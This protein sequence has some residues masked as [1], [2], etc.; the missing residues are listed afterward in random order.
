MM[1]THMLMV[2]F[3]RREDTMEYWLLFGEGM[4]FLYISLAQHGL[5]SHK[6]LIV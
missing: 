4:L 1:F 3:S 5:F 2:A 6:L